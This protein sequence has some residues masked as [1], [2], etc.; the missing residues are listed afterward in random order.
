MHFGKGLPKQAHR[1]VQ[2]RQDI[3]ALRQ[4]VIESEQL[5]QAAQRG[6]AAVLG[7]VAWLVCHRLA[8][9]PLNSSRTLPPPLTS[10]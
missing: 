1:I 3:A 10:S 9:R 6:R 2:I 5:I 4:L 8:S 7:A